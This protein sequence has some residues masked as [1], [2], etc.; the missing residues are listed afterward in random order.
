MAIFNTIYQA[1]DVSSKW[2]SPK[3]TAN[4]APSPYVASADSEY[5]STGGGGTYY[6]FRAFDGKFSGN[7]LSGG[8]YS[9]KP[10]AWIQFD[11]GAATSVAGIRMLPKMYSNWCELFP[12]S[13]TIHW[14]DDGEN[15][16]MLV[17]DDGTDYDPYSGEW[18]EIMFEHTEKHRYFRISCLS[19]YGQYQQS[20]IDEIEFAV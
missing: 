15:W 13:F 6:A 3:M 10:N 9:S 19:N 8:W 20:A 5:T 11:F 16:T 2:W 4:N 1:G 14:S 17:A 18:R 12:K 7:S